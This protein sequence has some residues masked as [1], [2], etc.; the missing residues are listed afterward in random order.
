MSNERPHRGGYRKRYNREDHDHDRR[1]EP[2]ETPEQKIRTS[3][4]KMGEVDP[5]QEIPRLAQQIRE[6][7]PVVVPAISEGFRIGVTEQPYKIPYYA[8][9]LRLLHDQVEGDTNGAPSST[10][11][12]LG[13]QILEDFWKGFQAFLDKLAWREIRLCIQFF[14][15][16]MAAK[17]ISVQSMVYLLQAFST[18]LDEFGVS[19]S[20]GKRAALCAA[21]GLMIAGAPLKTVSASSV[22]GIINAIQM[23]NESIVTSKFLIQPMMSLCSDAT[24]LDNADELLDTALILLKSLEASNFAESSPAFPRPYLEY[25][26]PENTTSGPFEL[27]SILVPPEVIELDGLA[28]DAGEDAQIK[29]E[30]WPEYYLHL[31]DNTITPDPTTLPGFI[32]RSN[33]LDI[34]DIFEVNRKE[35][36]RLLLEYPKWNIPGTFKPQPGAPAA[37]EGLGGKDWQ[38]ESTIIETILGSLFILPDP[39]AKSVYQISLI[40]ELCKL[41]P[42][43]VGPAV[44]KSIRK[45]YNALSDGLDTEIARRFAEWFAVHMSNFGFQWVWKEWLPDLALTEQHPKRAFM[46]RALEFEMR[47]SYHDRILKTLPEPMQ[48]DP[49]VI[50]DQAPGPDFEYDEPTH[51]HHDAA[52]SVLNLLRGRSK[53]DEVMSH[54]DS[55]RDT[56]EIS[57]TH[58]NIDTLIRFIAVQSLL[59][60]GSRSFSHL[61][62]AIERYLP[63]LRGLANGGIVGAGSGSSEAKQDILSAAAA[64]WKRNRQMVNIVFDKLMQYQIVD[65]TDVVAWTFTNVAGDSHLSGMRPLSLSAFEWDLLKGALDKAN[66]RVMISRRKVAALRKEED[67]TIARAKASGGADVAS[68]EVD[69]DAKPD[70]T[71]AVESPALVTALKAFTSL[72]R[73][74]K[75]ALSRTLEGF[76]SCLAPS[77]S[78]MHQNPHA[79]KVITQDAWD[80]RANWNADE[81]NAWETWGWYRHYCRVYSPYLR[82]YATTLSTVAFAKIEGSTEPPAELMKKIW[83]IT[84][85]QES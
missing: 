11:S 18:V 51:P 75:A 39:S 3:I 36:A 85:G 21:E 79:G 38:L 6:Q 71:P 48:L 81:W 68:M 2:V 35:C 74:Q 27:P 52:Q 73:E 64:F 12:S 14:A 77:V 32:V 61:L 42:S 72:T 41:S 47:L 78:D 46:R 58:M 26:D 57:D 30:D 45:L 31:F 69:A 84:T 59:S 76:V 82:N 65:P 49:T 40:T 44:G 80:G 54:L 24:S 17:V 5:L 8:A 60:I 22:A 16:L 15:H 23:Y 1:R 37:E 28:T 62:N 63:L 83:N 67:D 10:S 53:A 33:L 4:I 55:L 13:K 25:P 56:L 70:E 50:S 20:R 34:I 9:L 29:K 7:V 19:Y 43:T 66:G